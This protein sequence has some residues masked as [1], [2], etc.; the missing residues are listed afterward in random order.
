M[1]WTAYPNAGV[2]VGLGPSRWCSGNSL[3]RSHLRPGSLARS[4]TALIRHR[5]RRTL[6]WRPS[7]KASPSWRSKIERMSQRKEIKH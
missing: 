4:Q 6:Q 5:Y 3:A 2:A 1:K 7:A